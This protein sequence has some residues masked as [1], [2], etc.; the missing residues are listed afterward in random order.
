MNYCCVAQTQ[1]VS[2][3]LALQS[4]QIVKS[5]PFHMFV[6]VRPHHLQCVKDLTWLRME[7]VTGMRAAWAVVQ[8]PQVLLLDLVSI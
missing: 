5:D 7:A 6:S 2:D 4:K 1:L 3:A 8:V